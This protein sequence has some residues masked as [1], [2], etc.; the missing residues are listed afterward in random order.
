MQEILGDIR[1]KRKHPQDA[2]DT[3]SVDAYKKCGCIQ[4]ASLRYIQTK[5][6]ELPVY[7]E[8]EDAKDEMTFRFE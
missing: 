3:L 2:R 4:E 6:A 5:R 7:A 1:V 8:N